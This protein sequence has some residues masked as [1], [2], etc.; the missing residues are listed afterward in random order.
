M[1]FPP[2]LFLSALFHKFA[3]VR[4]ALAVRVGMLPTNLSLVR[5]KHPMNRRNVLKSVLL[6]VSALT[7][8]PSFATASVRERDSTMRLAELE[9]Q[10]GGRLGV[11]IQDTGSLRRVL[12]RADERFMMCSTFKLLLVGATLAR[13]DRG[14]ERLDRRVVFG[15]E[16]LVSFAPITGSHVGVPGMTVA[17]LCQAAV[18]VSDGVAAN[19]LLRRLGGPSALTAYA[20]GLGDAHTRLDR[21]E[22][23]MN[24]PAP[25]HVSDTTTPLAMLHDLRSLVLGDELSDAS[26]RLLVGWLREASTGLDLLRAGIPAGWHVGDKTGHGNGATNDVAII[27][28]PQRKPLLISTYYRALT[29]DDDTRPAALFADVGRI[30]VAMLSS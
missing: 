11:A 13:V 15:R 27:W 28:P 10:Y 25:D 3:C 5:V 29:T 9:R 17:E 30:A 6:G 12:Y 14:A 18:T 26:R 21:Y 23:E 20:R 7:L 24:R 4:A 22:P 19:L 2:P 1:D 16:A 8:R